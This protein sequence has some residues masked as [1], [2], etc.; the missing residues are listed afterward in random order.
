MQNT[1]YLAFLLLDTCVQRASL[2]KRLNWHNMR[3]SMIP[4]NIAYPH[5]H[6]RESLV[7]AIVSKRVS[8]TLQARE[9]LG[10]SGI[11]IMMILRVCA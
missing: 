5:L 3:H 11:S 1:L 10:A 7:G 6:A 8:R 2:R 4:F 9:Q